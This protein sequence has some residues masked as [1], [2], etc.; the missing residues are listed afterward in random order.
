[1]RISDLLRIAVKNLKGRWAI[2]P[3]LGAAISTFCFCFSGAVLASVDEEK[4]LPYELNISVGSTDLSDGVIAEISRIPGV[5]AAT[6]ILQVP[7]TVK[8]GE[9]FAKLTLTGIDAAYLDGEY[10]QGNDFPD[11]SVMPYIVLSEAACK[12]FSSDKSQSGFETEDAQIDWIN[13]K[14]TVQAGGE[15][16]PAVSKISGIMADEEKGQPGAAYISI[17]SAKELLRQSG[18][19]GDYSGVYVRIKNIGYAQSVSRAI[20]A[21][22]LEAANSNEELQAKWD[23]EMKELSYLIVI[24]V[25]SLLC[26]A[27]LMTAWRKISLLEHKEAY[28]ALRWIGMK[29]KEIGRL[30]IVQ[31]AIIS[32]F[33]IAA[34]ILVSVSLPSFL[35]P[36]PEGISIFTL[37]VPFWAA[38]LSAAVCAAAGMLPLLNIKSNVI[39]G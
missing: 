29:G 10:K 23:A 7:A 13:A 27:F 38:V 1:M 33:G 5:T 22:G 9:Y 24:G 39:I 12:Q 31:S 2:L 8:A 4:S 21:Q 20:S 6:P 17:S 3:A 36:E 30:F 32:M 18:Q 25:F 19:P 35:T 14:V 26:C 28:T 15:S 34:G 37:Q 11:S 16:R